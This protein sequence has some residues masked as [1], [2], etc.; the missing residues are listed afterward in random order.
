L[1]AKQKTTLYWGRT[2]GAG[3]T[4]GGHW[5]KKSGE[6]Q[7]IHPHWNPATLNEPP[8]VDEPSAGERTNVIRESHAGG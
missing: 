2:M 8:R 6:R 1:N 7:R 3:Q 5:K 4:I